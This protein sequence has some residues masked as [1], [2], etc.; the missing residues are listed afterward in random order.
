MET[1]GIVFALIIA[2]ALARVLWQ[3][4]QRHARRREAH[5]FVMAMEA[6]ASNISA[7][8][9]AWR[10]A[11]DWRYGMRAPNGC[12][13]CGPTR[14]WASHRRREWPRCSRQRHGCR[15]VRE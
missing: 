12:S 6:L 5:R 11:M 7:A 8:V 3:L 15:S 2:I 1:F 14:P 13:D 10:R 4:L 9:I